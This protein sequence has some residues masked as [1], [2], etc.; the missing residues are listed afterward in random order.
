MLGVYEIVSVS[1]EAVLEERNPFKPQLKTAKLP[2]EQLVK[3][4]SLHKREMP[5]ILEEDWEGHAV[6]K[7][8]EPGIQAKKA[9]I[10][11]A[12]LQ[13]A[14]ENPVTPKDVLLCLQPTHL[15]A[16][17][18]FEKGELVLIPCPSSMN[19]I[20]AKSASATDESVANLVDTGVDLA[21]GDDNVRFFI[22]K[23]PQPTKAFKDWQQTDMVN[24]YFWV[25]TS[26]DASEAALTAK[27]LVVQDTGLKVPILTNKRA[28][29]KFAPLKIF[30]DV[31]AAAPLQG[32]T[33]AKATSPQAAAA[34]EGA[35]RLRS[36]KP[37]PSEAK[38]AS[39]A[40][41]AAKRSRVR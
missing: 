8:S 16:A 3:G 4:W 6:H 2:F 1:D 25:T 30:K 27:T 17:R 33:V 41:K 32:P 14:T 15:R 22:S 26:S 20:S 10:Y 34:K 38:A 37:P 18:D 11:Q 39:P 19:S 40:P 36:K 24:P 29:K 7:H 31:V 12:L 21:V 23:P 35:C 9:D 5:Q 28:V 13:A